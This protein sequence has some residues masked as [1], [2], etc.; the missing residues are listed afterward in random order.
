MEL[1]DESRIIPVSHGH[2]V[3][4]RSNIIYLENID[5]HALGD[6]LDLA[7]RERF[8]LCFK[9]CEEMLIL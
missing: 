4:S 3:S 5:M 6:F 8:G 1:Y 2:C 7:C 9:L